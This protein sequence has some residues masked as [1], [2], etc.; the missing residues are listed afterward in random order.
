[1]VPS[2]HEADEGLL[3]FRPE[4]S[5]SDSEQLVYGSES[6]PRLFGVES[7]QLLT[8]GKV[9]E[10]EVLA[11][12]ERSNNPSEEVPKQQNHGRILSDDSK[13]APPPSC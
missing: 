7:Q 4:S 3:P 11:G 9:F 10:D 8:Q 2:E 13:T 5:Q 1:V 6:P 12:T